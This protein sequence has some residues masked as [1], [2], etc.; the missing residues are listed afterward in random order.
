MFAPVATLSGMLTL[1]RPSASRPGLVDF[2]RDMSEL[3]ELHVYTAGSRTYANAVCKGL[4]P[5]G[6]YFGD[7]ILSRDE[8]GSECLVGPVGQMIHRGLTFYISLH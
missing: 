8:S 5:D 4:D 7:R 1:S 3:Y 6:R 2:L